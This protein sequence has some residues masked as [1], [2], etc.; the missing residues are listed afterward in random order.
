MFAWRIPGTGEPGGLPS[1]M[2]HRVGYDWSNLAAAAPA[3]GYCQYWCSEYGSTHVSLRLLFHFLWIYIQ[4]RIYPE[5]WNF[6]RNFLKVFHGS[7]T[8]I[9]SY[10][11][12]LRSPFS[13]HPHHTYF[14]LFGKSHL[15]RSEVVCVV[16][17]ISTSLIVML[18][19]LSYTSWAFRMSYLGGKLSIL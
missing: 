3:E 9:R 8:N 12:S 2:S 6:M 16:L 11:Y 19:I 14:L 13:T 17:L 5:V 7:C 1:M 10:Q 15:N 18:I 4:K